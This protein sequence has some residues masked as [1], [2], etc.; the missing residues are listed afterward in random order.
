MHMNPICM[1]YPWLYIH[2]DLR[3]NISYTVYRQVWL[4]V[5]DGTKHEYPPAAQ[6][7]IEEAYQQQRTSVDIT[8][9]V[10]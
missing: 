5:G 1:Y 2:A 3:I 8:V 10:S 6:K 7:A 4:V 9:R